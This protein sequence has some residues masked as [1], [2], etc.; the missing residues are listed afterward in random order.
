MQDFE[1]K[2][3]FQA[4]IQRIRALELD[5]KKLKKAYK[6]KLE[7]LFLETVATQEE[8]A[9]QKDLSMKKNELIASQNDERNALKEAIAVLQRKNAHLHHEAAAKEE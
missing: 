1:P 6:G 7:D 9:L 3:S 4:N 5:I 8:L 2:K